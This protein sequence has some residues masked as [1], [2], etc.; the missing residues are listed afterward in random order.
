MPVDLPVRPLVGLL[1][2]LANQA[3]GTEVDAALSEAGF[4][5]IRPAHAN[6]FPFVGPDGVSVAELARRA[7]MRKQSMA[8]AVEQ[9]EKLGYVERRPDPTDG[10]ARRVFLTERGRAV[11]PVAVRAGRAVEARWSDAVG[12]ERL[13]QM[14]ET[15]ADLL[16][17]PLR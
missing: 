2:R 13:E 5:G 9:L 3:Y 1:L 15:L 17:P 8:Q 11:G 14:R 10:R 7:R 4:A 6:V 12:A 16:R